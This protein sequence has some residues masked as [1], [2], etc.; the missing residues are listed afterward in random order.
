[1]NTLEAKKALRKEIKTL[2]AHLT[3]AQKQEAEEK[4]LGGLLCD[5]KLM[6]CHNIIAYSSLP[7]ELPTERII[8]TL[9][10]RGHSV[11]LPVI[12]GDNIEFHQYNNDD[13]MQVDNPYGI[14][15]PKQ[16][17][18]LPD[19]EPVSIIV[20]GI[21]FT[22]NGKRL[23]RGGGYYDRFLETKKNSYKVGVGFLCQCV[24]DIP[25]EDFDIAMDR[26]IFG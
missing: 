12:N 20:P 9:I 17:Q 6:S 11:Y 22:A 10:S 4:V 24:E 21:A 23:G 16:G 2:K 1:M 25:T 14:S 3:D 15:E 19:N 8:R 18:I 7:D 5:T 13:E 26:V